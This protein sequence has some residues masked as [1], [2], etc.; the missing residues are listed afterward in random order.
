MFAGVLWGII[1]GIAGRLV[2]QEQRGRGLTIAL[3]GD[4]SRWPSALRPER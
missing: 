3:A 1:A 4:R 2:S